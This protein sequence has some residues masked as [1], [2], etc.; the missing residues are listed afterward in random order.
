MDRRQAEDD[1]HLDCIGAR[2]SR[3]EQQRQRDANRREERPPTYPEQR[4][5]GST[6]LGAARL[7]PA[8][9]RQRQA[10]SAVEQESRD[11]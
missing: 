8:E 4:G 2:H 10:D 9:H 11:G 7:A 5:F 1:G 6:R 3:R